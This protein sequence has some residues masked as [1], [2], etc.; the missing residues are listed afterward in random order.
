MGKF[1]NR[2]A[3]EFTATPS[4]YPQ[5]N[6]KPKFCRWCETSFKPVGPSHHYCSDDCRRNAYAD[7]YYT[8]RY[9]VGFRWILEQLDKQNWLCKI[10]KT[11]GFK[12]RDSHVSGLNLDHCHNSGVV[13]GLLCHNCNR[14]LGLFQDN[15]QYLRE[16]AIYVED[17]YELAAD[18]KSPGKRPK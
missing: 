3:S 12:M 18:E 10:C 14:G 13:R 7:K 9:G 11:S 8:S 5:R 4:K 15:P 2:V 16:A 6:F 1:Q 17:G